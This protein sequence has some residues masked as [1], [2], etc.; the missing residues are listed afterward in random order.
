[1]LLSNSVSVP[2]DNIIFS[3]GA[4]GALPFLQDHF[5]TLPWAVVW[6]IFIFNLIIKYGMTLLSLPLIY[7][8]PNQK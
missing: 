4:F 8:S 5:L 2:I 3:V 6:E 7:L 1:V